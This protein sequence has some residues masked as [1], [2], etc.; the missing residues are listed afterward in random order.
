MS[1][2]LLDRIESPADLRALMQSAL[3]ESADAG[4]RREFALAWQE[5][6]RRILVERAADP[7]LVT[8]AD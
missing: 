8:F 1:E 2:R 4:A 7:E 6:V 3:V 5:W